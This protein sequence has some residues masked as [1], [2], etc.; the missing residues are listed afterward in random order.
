[1]RGVEA[2]ARAE[3]ELDLH[4]AS[5]RPEVENDAVRQDVVAAE[6]PATLPDGGVEGFPADFGAGRE[7]DFRQ[8]HSVAAE[9]NA[10]YP[11]FARYNVVD[12]G[13]DSVVRDRQTKPIL[14]VGAAGRLLSARAFRPRDVVAG[15]ELDRGMWGTCRAANFNSVASGGEERGEIEPGREQL[16]R[17]GGK[18][19]DLLGVGRDFESR[20]R[21]RSIA[22]AA[23]GSKKG[24]QRFRDRDSGLGRVPDAVAVLA[25]QQE[26]SL[27]QG[28]ALRGSLLPAAAEGFVELDQS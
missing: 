13:F 28:P 6:R 25:A 5:A 3:G 7:A 24:G 8:H 12:P 23:D 4:P 17:R 16:I 11:D 26:E 15:D 2:E 20:S 21:S 14:A 18:S 9:T 10:L 19:R 27:S 1:M 22:R